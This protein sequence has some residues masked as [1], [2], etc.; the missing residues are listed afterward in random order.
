[1]ALIHKGGLFGMSS[2]NKLLIYLCNF[3]WN[4]CFFCEKRQKVT[5][6]ATYF[7]LDLLKNNFST[8]FKLGNGHLY[9]VPCFNKQNL[10]ISAH[11]VFFNLWK[12]LI[13]YAKNTQKHSFYMLRAQK[14]EQKI[15]LE[16]KWELIR[17]TSAAYINHFCS[18]KPCC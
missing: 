5:F 13:L 9:H 17:N 1:M 4:C 7:G 15:S 8:Y 12:S 14:Y 18:L 11:F 6:H 2:K 10:I 3:F 16:I